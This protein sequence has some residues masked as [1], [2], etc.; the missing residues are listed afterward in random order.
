MESTKRAL[1][2]GKTKEENAGWAAEHVREYLQKSGFTA[3]WFDTESEEGKRVLTEDNLKQ[4]DLI[5]T[6]DLAGFERNTQSGSFLYNI[7]PVKS[8][9]F[10]EKETG[11]ACERLKNRKISIALFFVFLGMQE[12]E[13][14]EIEKELPEIPWMQ[15]CKI[16]REEIEKALADILS[17]IFLEK[18]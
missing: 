7:L 5:V 16:S 12:A 4:A 3:E 11:T 1:L 13:Y 17:E 6:F 14:K 18:R 15:L 10:V 2:L 9:H 8:I